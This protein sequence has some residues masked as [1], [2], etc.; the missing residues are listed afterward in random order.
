MNEAFET[1]FKANVNFEGSADKDKALQKVV[2]DLCQEAFE[3][4]RRETLKEVL[5]EINNGNGVTKLIYATTL[6]SKISKMLEDS[7]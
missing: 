5:K 4:S 1:H 3:A 6:Y 7:R 2:K